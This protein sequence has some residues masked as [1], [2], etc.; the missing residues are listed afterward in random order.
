MMMVM[1]MMMMM[2]VK[3][4]TH[5]AE[6]ADE[7]ECVAVALRQQHLIRRTPVVHDLPTSP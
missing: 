7:V 2:A 3:V 4:V 6:D 5:R 1:V